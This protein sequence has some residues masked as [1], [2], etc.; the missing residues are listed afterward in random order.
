MFSFNTFASVDSELENDDF[1]DEESIVE[2]VDDFDELDY[3]DDYC[4]DSDQD[5][6]DSNAELRNYYYSNMTY[7]IVVS[8][9]N[10]SLSS[11]NITLVITKIGYEK[12]KK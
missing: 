3:C 9:F 11:D 5:L 12:V 4:I 2:N 1:I 10:S 6:Y 7:F 8:K